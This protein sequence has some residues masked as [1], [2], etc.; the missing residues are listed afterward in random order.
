MLESLVSDKRSSLLEPFIMK[1]LK[2]ADTSFYLYLKNVPNMHEYNVGKAC[3]LQT[4]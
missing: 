1:N 3:L 2:C 4:L